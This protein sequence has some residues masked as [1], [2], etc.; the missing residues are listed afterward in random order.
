MF[1]IIAISEEIK[2]VVGNLHPDWQV[3]S[4]HDDFGD[5]DR[6]SIFLNYFRPSDL[7]PGKLQAA[8]SFYVS[9]QWI[10]ISGRT[11]IPHTAPD[12]KADLIAALGAQPVPAG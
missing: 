9:P 4:S 7:T 5:Y 12:W 6:H 11:V 10:R 2:N 3:R 8:T 1:D